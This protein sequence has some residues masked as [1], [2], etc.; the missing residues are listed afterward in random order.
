[1][2]VGVPQKAGYLY[3]DGGTHSPDGHCRAFDAEAM[4]MVGGSGVGA[5]VLKR[6]VGCAGGPRPRAGRREGHRHQ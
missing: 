2:S 1:V 3:V 4:G 6:A 5:I